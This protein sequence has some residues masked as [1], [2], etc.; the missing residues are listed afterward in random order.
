LNNSQCDQTADDLKTA[1][2]DPFVSAGIIPIWLGASS[3]YG[4]PPVQTQT[5]R[6]NARVSSYCTWHGNILT[7]MAKNA[8]WKTENYS[9]ITTDVHPNDAGH[10]VFKDLAWALYRRLRNLDSKL[11]FGSGAHSLSIGGGTSSMTVTP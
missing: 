11:I 6:F 9:D 8:N 2:L 3:W 1:I 5:E 10:T 4:N 7:E